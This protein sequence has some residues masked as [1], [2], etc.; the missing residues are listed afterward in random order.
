MKGAEL[1]NIR[2]RKRLAR[3]KIVRKRINDTK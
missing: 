3:E 1:Y 2:G